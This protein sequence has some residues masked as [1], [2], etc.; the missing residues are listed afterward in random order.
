MIDDVL[1]HCRTL[2][3]E[4][5]IPHARAPT[6]EESGPQQSELHEPSHPYKTGSTKRSW[7]QHFI[8]VDVNRDIL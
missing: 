6:L 1:A 4:H 7:L 2:E 8:I 3:V 5:S